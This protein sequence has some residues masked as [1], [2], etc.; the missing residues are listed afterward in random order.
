AAPRAEDR[1][2]AA[3]P[4]GGKGAEARG[5]GPAAAEHGRLGPRLD[6]PDHPEPAR[7]DQDRFAG[8]VTAEAELGLEL[9]IDEA[10]APPLLL[11]DQRE[12]PAE[13][14]GPAL[15]L[16]PRRLNPGHLDVGLRP[17]AVG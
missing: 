8:R 1:R 14:H 13:G 4:G 7:A 5:P 6:H 2:L 11:V 17:V 16:V 3:A 10:D 12:R 9:G 15:D